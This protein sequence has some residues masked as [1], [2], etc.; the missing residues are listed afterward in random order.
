MGRF[1]EALD[2]GRRA[3]EI[4]KA[5]PSDQYLSFKAGFAICLA[6]SLMGDLRSAKAD[7]QALLDYGW[8]HSNHRG[9]VLGYFAL[10]IASFQRGDMPASIDY[11]EKCRDAARDP[12][13]ALFYPHMVGSVYVMTGRPEEAEKALATVIT[14]RDK[15][16][17]GMIAGWDYLFL[18]MARIMRG[19][20]GEGLN[21]IEAL[22]D[23]FLDN[24]NTLW[25]ILAEQLLGNVYLK[26]VEGGG[27]LSLRTVVKNLPFLVTNVP[28]ADGKAQKHL[29]EAIRV[30][31]EIG[32]NNVLGQTYLSL[33]LLHKAKK[34]KDKAIEYLSEAMRLLGECGAD[35]PM[36]EAEEALKSLGMLPEGFDDHE[37]SQM[38]R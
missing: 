13:F 30:S 16:D 32:S 21:A 38:P 15:F 1:E 34:R 17:E 3:L 31:R 6:H 9:L 35:V 11:G 20:M 14:F 10:A 23:E 25:Y 12:L 5:I 28:F 19:Q 22:R 4:G 8:E 37:M 27:P 24:G 2:A 7:G 36:R 18:A 26:M 29:E 33:G